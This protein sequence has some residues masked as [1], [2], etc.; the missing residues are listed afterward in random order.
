MLAMMDASL[1]RLKVCRWKV[2]TKWKRESGGEDE[3]YEKLWAD[4]GAV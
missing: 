3:L 2:S 4:G 1:A